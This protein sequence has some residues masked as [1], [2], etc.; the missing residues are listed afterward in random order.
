MKLGFQPVNIS[1]QVYG[2]AVYPTGTSPWG[3]AFTSSA[4]VS[5]VNQG[6][7]EDAARAKTETDGKG[8][9]AEVNGRL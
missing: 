4:P 8:A 7:A 6:S 2:N 3:P 5:Q 9:S 1:A